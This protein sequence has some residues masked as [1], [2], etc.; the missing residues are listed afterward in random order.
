MCH[1]CFSDLFLTIEKFNSFLVPLEYHKRCPLFYTTKFVPCRS[2]VPYFSW[3][4]TPKREKYTKWRQNLPKCS[5]ILKL[6]KNIFYSKALQNLPLPNWDFWNENIPSGKPDVD[7]C[8]SKIFQ[9]VS[10]FRP[11]GPMGPWLPIRPSDPLSPLGPGGPWI[12]T[13]SG[14]K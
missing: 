4:Y 10:P 12:R 6:K 9:P 1:A 2:G 7:Y 11:L 8:K 14:I 3:Y 13:F 5:K